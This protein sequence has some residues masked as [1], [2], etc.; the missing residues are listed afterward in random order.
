MRK[1]IVKVVYNDA[2]AKPAK[3][4]SPEA[5]AWLKAH[6]Y[7]GKLFR[8]DELIIS[9]HHPLLVACVEELGDTANGSDPKH[10]FKAELRIAEID[11]ESYYVFDYD[12]KETVIGEKDLISTRGKNSSWTH[13]RRNRYSSRPRRWRCGWSPAP[14]S[15]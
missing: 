11:G 6:G 7:G 14:D 1:A 9:R 4:L 3:L 8:A 5:V 12:G 2:Y 15:R 10:G 13:S